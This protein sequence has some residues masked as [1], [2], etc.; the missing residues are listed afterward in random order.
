MA[1]VVNWLE[2]GDLDAHVVVRAAMAHLHVVSV[3]PFRDG[4]GRISR[5]TQSLVLAREGLLSPEFA[6]IEECLAAHTPD[7]YRVLQEVQGGSYL[8]ARDAT[9]WVAFCIEAHLVQ[10]RRRL[11]QIQQAAIRWAHLEQRVEER[12][13]PDRLVV[14]LE[15]A[16]I[17]GTDRARYG[18][19]ADIS[20]ASATNDLRRLLDSGL[21]TRLGR[22]R[23]TRYRAS[24]LLRREVEQALSSVE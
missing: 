12:G 18:A 1:E 5:I 17:R 11:E 4:N 13:W 19:E 16:L 21:I 24:D 9:P 7:Y 2:H 10:A 14:A 20:D 22:G 6:S 23:N 8:P 15:Q 3:H